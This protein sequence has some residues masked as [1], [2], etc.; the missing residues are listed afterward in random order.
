MAIIPTLACLVLAT[1]SRAASL[2]FDLPQLVNLRVE[3]A[4]NRTIFEG[5]ILTRGHDVATPSGGTHH[6]DGTNL[7]ANPKPGATCTAALS[8]AAHLAGFTFDG[9][10]QDDFD[11][12]FITRVAS[13]AQTATQFWG[14][15]LDFQF[16]PVG[17]C[18]QEVTSGADVLWAF[19]AFSAAHFLKLAGSS[20]VAHVDETLTFTVTD[21][22]SGTPV[23][24]AEMKVRQAL[25]SDGSFVL[26]TSD[27][28]GH[29][30]IRPTA[31]GTLSLKAAQ[32]GSIQSNRVDILVLP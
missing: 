14:L 32:Q 30:S 9:T 27:A 17:G 19:D 6:C 5:P 16:T 10:F 25:Y 4:H 22:T 13:S 24:G 20:S 31:P 26:G 18:Q 29:V 7:G 12:F 8:D 2:D 11:D 1:L 21:G 15:L 23:A 3:G 28:A